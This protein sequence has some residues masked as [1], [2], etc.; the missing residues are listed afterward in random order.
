M[1][2]AETLLTMLWFSLGRLLDR[3]PA[4]CAF[5]RGGSSGDSDL[6]PVTTLLAPQLSQCRTLAHRWFA[7]GSVMPIDSRCLML[8][9]ALAMGLAKYRSV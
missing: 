9:C 7:C 4:H 6:W 8:S 1:H 3:R 5:R 2:G